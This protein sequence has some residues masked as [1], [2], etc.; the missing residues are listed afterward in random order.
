[1]EKWRKISHISL[2]IT[3]NPHD[4]TLFQYNNQI[5]FIRN[6]LIIIILRLSSHIQNLRI[7]ISNISLS[8]QIISKK[9]MPESNQILDS[10][11]FQNLNFLVHGIQ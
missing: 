7:L 2:I 9:E 11:H 1:M 3:R 4:Q 10:P 8:S 5:I 6:Y